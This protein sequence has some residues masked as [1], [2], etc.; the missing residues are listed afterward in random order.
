MTESFPRPLSPVEDELLRFFL[1]HEFPGVT[2]LREQAKSVRVRGLGEGS[3]SIVLLEVTDPAAPRAD[4]S[5]A[6]PIDA[7]VRGVTPLRE[8]LLFISDGLLDSIELVDY[9]GKDPRALPFPSELDTPTVYPV[10]DDLWHERGLSR[11]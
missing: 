6:V 1:S 9:S 8:V 3:P 2:E 11:P 10:G 5:Y 7:H 4:T